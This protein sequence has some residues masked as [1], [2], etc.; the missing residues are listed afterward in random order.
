MIARANYDAARDY[1]TI[2][3]LGDP[4]FDL[5]KSE[6]GKEQSWAMFTHGICAVGIDGHLRFHRLAF[7]GGQMAEP[8]VTNLAEGIEKAALRLNQMGLRANAHNPDNRTG[9]QCLLAS[10]TLL[11]EQ[12]SLIEAFLGSYSPVAK[13]EPG[14]V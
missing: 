1:F 6:I 5:E 7:V 4:I 11:Q 8:S 13:L 10:E 2:E 12:N 9:K 14:A 3:F